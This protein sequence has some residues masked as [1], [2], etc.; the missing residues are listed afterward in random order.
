MALAKRELQLSGKERGNPVSYLFEFT[1]TKRAWLSGRALSIFVR[2]PLILTG[3]RVGT[4]S[5]FQSR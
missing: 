2:R 4:Y 3:D 5:V 1:I